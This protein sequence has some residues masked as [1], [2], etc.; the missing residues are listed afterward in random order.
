M[1]S[2][3]KKNLIISSWLN[4]VS[5]R[6]PEP[7]VFSADGGVLATF[8]A[9]EQASLAFTREMSVFTPGQIVA[10]QLGNQPDWP[11][12][13][14]ALMR[15]GLIPLPLGRHMGEVERDVALQTCQAAGLIHAG[16]H[17]ALEFR[18]LAGC[19]A[20]DCDFL[21]LTYGTGAAPRAIRFQS[22]QLSA[23]CDSICDTMS[24]TR[25]DLQFGGVPFSHSYGLSS[26]ILP[27][28]CRAVPM[29]ACE[30][31]MPRSIL[32]DLA[33]T[34]ATVFPGMPIFYQA[35]AEMENLPPLPRLRLCISAGAPL[36]RAIAEN[37]TRKFA[38]KIHTFYGASECGGI[39]YDASDSPDYEDAA[40]GTPMQNVEV[41]FL[42]SGRLEIRSPSLGDGYF[43]EPNRLQLDG[44]RFIPPDLVGQSKRGMRLTG[45]VS[46]VIN[47]AGRKLNPGEVEALLKR[48]PGVEEVVVFGIPSL[49]RNEEPVACIVSLLSQNDLVQQAQT[50]L[51]A[52]QMP[53]DFWRVDAIPN[54][55]RRELAKA[56]LKQKKQ[57]N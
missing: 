9:I 22:A 25:N 45:T 36:P 56:Y 16:P 34:G 48:L 50:V 8:D 55:E 29:V 21:K 15:C 53:R 40:L 7:A 51:S 26:L 1:T 41:K 44:A 43:P 38:K 18:T 35:F 23:D 10:F 27:L 42:E 5:R 20:P 3:N 30:D 33:L 13:L 28:L 49:L 17:G 39:G 19:G 12:L 14:L 6:G 52:W 54:P 4:T 11:A 2:A 47:I 37:F 57:F 31:R 24:I 32:S 46:D